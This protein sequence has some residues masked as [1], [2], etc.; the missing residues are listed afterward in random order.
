MDSLIWYT[1][2]FRIKSGILESSQESKNPAK[3]PKDSELRRRKFIVSDPSGLAKSKIHLRDPT[4]GPR[5]WKVFNSAETA[6]CI[7]TKKLTHDEC[8]QQ[9]L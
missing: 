1:G 9:V 4:I 8:R 7:R 6:I 2:I 3:I 5:K